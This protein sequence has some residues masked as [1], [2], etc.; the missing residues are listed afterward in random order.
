MKFELNGQLEEV[1]DDLTVR[2]LLERFHLQRGRVAV[3][4]NSRVIPRSRFDD[5]E[6]REGDAVEVIQAVG[7]G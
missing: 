2:L 1:E 6:I 4:I 5:E 3:A 7:G